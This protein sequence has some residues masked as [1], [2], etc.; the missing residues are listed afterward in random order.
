MYYALRASGV[1]VGDEVLVQ[2]YTCLVV[3]NAIKWAGAT[4][5]YVDI[6]DNFNI[7]PNDLNKK[8]TQRSKVLIIQHTFGQPADLD[9]LL[10]LAKQ[11]G[12]K[13]IEDCA[14]AL[15]AKYKG[16]LLGTF[17]DIG[18]FS[19]GSDK[20]VSCVRGGALITNDDAIFNKLTDDH[21]C[22]PRTARLRLIQHLFHYP[23][24]FIGKNLYHLGI[25]KCLLWLAKKVHLISKIIYEPEKVGR[26]VA[27][28]PALLPNALAVILLDQLKELDAVNQHRLKIARLYSSKIKN[29]NIQLPKFSSGSIPLRYPLL[30]DNPKILLNRGAKQ[31]V[32]L[33]DWYNRVVAPSDSDL[34]KTGYKAG[35]CPNAE[36]LAARSVNLPTDRQITTAAGLRIINAVLN[37]YGD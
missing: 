22:L 36:R 6:N 14:H 17:G 23:V 26:P 37:Q 9:Q 2:A 12:L 18:L 16:R 34:S 35:A 13:T 15:G 30:A 33:G 10:P 19:F 5:V 29:R 7:N 20:P 11:H 21:F 24:F 31:G 8:I 1:G 4:P 27:F 25:G 28:Y 3:I 32:I